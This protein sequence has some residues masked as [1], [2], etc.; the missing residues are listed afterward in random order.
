MSSDLIPWASEYNICDLPDYKEIKN[1]LN[2]SKI[3]MCVVAT[4]G[5]TIRGNFDP[6]NEISKVCKKY[7]IWHHLD[8]AWRADA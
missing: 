7:G 2:E 8:A 4:G 6:I 1:T 5:T 3:P